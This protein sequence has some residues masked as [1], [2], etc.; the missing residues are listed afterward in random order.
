MMKMKMLGGVP[1]DAAWWRER[2]AIAIEELRYEIKELGKRAL[3]Y[4]RAILKLIHKCP[5]L[6]CREALRLI[7]SLERIK[8]LEKRKTS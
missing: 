8:K 1:V 3:G 7:K 5:Y 2:L 6:T 4:E